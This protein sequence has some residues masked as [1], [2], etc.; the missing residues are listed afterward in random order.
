MSPAL[1][2]DY[3]V[4]CPVQTVILSGFYIRLHRALYPAGDRQPALA[5]QWLACWGWLGSGK[6][7]LSTLFRSAATGAD[8]P[9]LW[10]S[11]R[12]CS[13]W[14]NP[15]RGLDPQPSP[16]TGDGGA[17]SW[18]REPSYCSFPHHADDAPRSDH[19]AELHYKG[20]GEGIRL[21]AGASGEL[22]RP[23]GMVREGPVRRGAAASQQRPPQP[24]EEHDPQ[25]ELGQIVTGGHIPPSPCECCPEGDEGEQKR[26]LCCP[27]W[28]S[29]LTRGGSGE[30]PDG[31]TPHQLIETHLHRRQ[32]SPGRKLGRWRIPAGSAARR[33]TASTTSET[34][35]VATEAPARS[36]RRRYGP[37]C[38]IPAMFH[39]RFRP[40]RSLQQF[41]RRRSFE[42]GQHKIACLQRLRSGHCRHP[43]LS[44]FCS[45]QITGSPSTPGPCT[46]LAV[47]LA[48]RASLFDQ[49]GQLALDIEPPAGRRCFAQA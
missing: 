25:P 3:R 27:S 36:G 13:S 9:C 37:R 44:G 6:R 31:G 8:R 17:P 20:R 42:F 46:S 12:R 39:P 16:G 4:S 28:R 19:R 5:N 45:S 33:H 11:I 2:L 34:C 49:A 10:S 24:E 21:S 40:T 1:H 30:M 35:G 26:A 7:S 22:S 41:P 48:I 15:C 32:R 38:H 23:G 47:E 18:A 14:T 29:F 43:S